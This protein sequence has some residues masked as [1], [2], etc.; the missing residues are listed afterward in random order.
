MRERSAFCFC[1][2]LLVASKVHDGGK[3][4]S[5]TQLTL[6]RECVRM[7]RNTIYPLGGVD[8]DHAGTVTLESIQVAYP[9]YAD[10]APYISLTGTVPIRQCLFLQGGRTRPAGPAGL[11]PVMP[12]DV[13]SNWACIR[14]FLALSA[15]KHGWRE[16]RHLVKHLSPPRPREQT[17][18]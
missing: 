14:L 12:S 7:A 5:S 13:L 2:I 4:K 11:L 8:D 9:C 17:Q 15:V 16:V 18:N 10:Y 3:S 6:E 1:A